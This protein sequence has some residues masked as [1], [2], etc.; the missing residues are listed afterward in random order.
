MYNSD[1]LNTSPSK[2]KKEDHNENKNLLRTSIAELN[3]DISS[4]HM[5]NNQTTG[6]KTK[7]KTGYLKIG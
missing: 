4:D 5:K 7:K 6:R 1:E 3:D 2:H